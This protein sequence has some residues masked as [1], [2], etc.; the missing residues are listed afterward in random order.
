MD[1]RLSGR[2]V[3]LYG[4]LFL[5]CNVMCTIQRSSSS[6][7]APVDS[8]RPRWHIFSSHRRR[9]FDNVTSFSC[10]Y[11]FTM[12]ISCPPVVVGMFESQHCH[13]VFREARRSEPLHLKW[14]LLLRNP[15]CGEIDRRRSWGASLQV[16]L[17]T[18]ATC[19]RLYRHTSL[20]ASYIFVR[21]LYQPWRL[22]QRV[23]P[24]WLK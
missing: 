22:R 6:C 19:D 10:S 11:V 23:N 3:P 12:M 18:F 17:L 9:S 8:K 16:P 13:L 15:L 2:Q 21:P 24:L 1:G 14:L 4:V 20:Q 5:F 7:A